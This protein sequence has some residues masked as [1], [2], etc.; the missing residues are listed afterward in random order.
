MTDHPYLSGNAL[1]CG[2]NL[3]ILKELPEFEE[4]L[5]EQHAA[6]RIH[7][8]TDDE[9]V[10]RF[11]R[12]HIRELQAIYGEQWNWPKYSSL[13]HGIVPVSPDDELGVALVQALY[14]LTIADQAL[15]THYDNLYDITGVDNVADALDPDNFAGWSAEQRRLEGIREIRRMTQLWRR[16]LDWAYDPET[17]KST[18][19]GSFSLPQHETLELSTDY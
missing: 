10:E 17:K 11:H 7:T 18:R 15:I 16:Y 19:R 4:F 8:P 5:T 2:D 1:V 12:A 9:E 14:D 6:P 13:M 3:D